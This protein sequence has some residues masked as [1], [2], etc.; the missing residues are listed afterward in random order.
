MGFYERRIDAGDRDVVQ[1]EVFRRVL[2]RVRLAAAVAVAHR[3]RRAGIH[4]GAG[5]CHRIGNAIGMAGIRCAAR[6]NRRAATAACFMHATAAGRAA[7]AARAA[8]SDSAIAGTGIARGHAL[9]RA[10]RRACHAC[11]ENQR[12][13][14]HAGPLLARDFSTAQEWRRRADFVPESALTASE[15][16]RADYAPTPLSCRIASSSSRASIVM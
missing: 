14:F 4:A 2:V 3:R 9:L 11:D 5:V 6:N 7:T 1:D 13:W 8:A 12:G 15:G 16:I 10:S